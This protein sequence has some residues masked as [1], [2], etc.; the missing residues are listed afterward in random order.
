MISDVEAVRESLSLWFDRDAEVAA[1]AIDGSHD[2][3]P[4]EQALVGQAVASRRAEFAAG[5]WCARA[6]LGRL[7]VAP[8][9]IPI[10][11]LRE[12]VAPEGFRLTIA[13]DGGLAVAV[14]ATAL[15]ACGLGIDLFPRGRTLTADLASHIARPHEMLSWAREV[16]EDNP[17][18]VLFACK[19]AVVK[20]ISSHVGRYLRLPD[21]ELVPDGQHFE[22]RRLGTRLRGAWW[23]TKDFIVAAAIDRRDDATGAA[24]G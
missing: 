3:F 18:P 14:A 16:E 4:E 19:E 6:A 21:V 24:G 15:R 7:G 20:T 8:T 12:P 5:R 13:H 10:G 9:A 11:G 1:C 23:R 22:L 2:L 17:L